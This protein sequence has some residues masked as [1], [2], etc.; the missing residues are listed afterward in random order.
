MFWCGSCSKCPWT[1]VRTIRKEPH[2]FYFLF[3]F[4]YLTKEPPGGSL[5]LKQGAFLLSQ[6]QHR[7]E[8]SVIT[9]HQSQNQPTES[10]FRREVTC[11]GHTASTLPSVYFWSLPPWQRQPIKMTLATTSLHPPETRKPISPLHIINTVGAE[12]MNRCESKADK[13]KRRK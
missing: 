7:H 11:H 4:V 9:N 10:T 2:V 6:K 12:E 5:R 13:L 3:C 8:S 1:S